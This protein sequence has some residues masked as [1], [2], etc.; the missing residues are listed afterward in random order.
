MLVSCYSC[1]KR[2]Q[3]SSLMP[4]FNRTVT[5]VKSLDE[6]FG[7]KGKQTVL[8]TTDEALVGKVGKIIKV[9][10]MLPATVFK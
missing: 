5:E 2:Q 6:L 4:S 1:Q 3:E 10:N 7:K 9:C 8:E